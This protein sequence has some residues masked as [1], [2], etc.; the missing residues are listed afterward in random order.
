MKKNKRKPM[1]NVNTEETKELTQQQLIRQKIKELQKLESIEKQ[2]STYKSK[3]EKLK[4]DKKLLEKKYN[5]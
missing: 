4:E 2:I 1:E 3:I 5:L